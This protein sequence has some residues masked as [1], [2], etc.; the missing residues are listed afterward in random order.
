MSRDVIVYSYFN[1]PPPYDQAPGL[2]PSA[3]KQEFYKESDINLIMSRHARGGALPSGD[4]LAQYGDF[5]RVDYRAMRDQVAR[6]SQEFE[7]LPSDLRRKFDNDPSSYY[8][9]VAEADGAQLREL[10]LD[11]LVDALG[12]EP[13]SSTSASASPSASSPPSAAS[14]PPSAAPAAV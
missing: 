6:A 12:I 1:P 9:F 13:S 11:A 2:E 3:T 4:R 14:V 5:T 8:S 7:A 10:G